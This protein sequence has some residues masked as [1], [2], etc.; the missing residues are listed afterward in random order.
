MVL[1]I[2]QA[3]FNVNHFSLYAH[4]SSRKRSLVVGIKGA[5]LG[6][7]RK[8]FGDGGNGSRAGEETG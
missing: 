7:G 1:N 3:V 6:K 2:N 5:V 8:Q 4:P